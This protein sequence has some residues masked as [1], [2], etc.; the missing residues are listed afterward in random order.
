MTALRALSTGVLDDFVVPARLEARSPAEER[1]IPRDA[2]R[3][4]VADERGIAHRVFSDLDEILEP[5]DL[6]IVNNSS[7]LAASVVVDETRAI[8]F[9][10][11]LPGGFYIVEPR[12]LSGPTS[13]PDHDVAPGLVRLPGGA[14]VELLAP[15]PADS[16]RAR[17][18]LS[19]LELGGSSLLEYLARWGRPIRY[20]HVDAP[21]PLESFQ[22]VFASVAGSAEMPSA[23][24]PFSAPL[25]A[26]LAAAGIGVAPITLHTGVSSLESG[27]APY[28]EFMDVSAST[29]ALVNHTRGRGGRVI[30]VGTTVVRALESA[31][32]TTGSAHP[33]R[34]WTD[35]VID[36]TH[37][38]RVIDGL[39]TGWHEPESTHLSMLEAIAGRAILSESYAAALDSGYLWH[40]FGDSLL[41]MRESQ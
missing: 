2:V 27:E 41:L 15:Y 32:D 21:Y 34:T 13:K 8:H 31:V 35:L 39:I 7:T 18:W 23:G 3:L 24:R 5:G 11:R 28:P 37:E 33:L 12:L 4:M 1:G 40:E 36:S 14:S 20:K 17:L 26:R 30:A 25:V 38:T 6:L 29:A 9:S 22:T 16:S 10:T 19:R